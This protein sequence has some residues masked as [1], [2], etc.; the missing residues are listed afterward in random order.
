MKTDTS[1]SVEQA[2]G[3]GYLFV[4]LP[5]FLCIALPLLISFVLPEKW[6]ANSFIGFAIIPSILLGWV[7]WSWALPRWRLWAVKRVDDIELLFNKAIQAQLM[8]PAGHF[9]Q[10]T[11]I[12]STKQKDELRRIMMEKMDTSDEYVVQ[13]ITKITT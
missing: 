12:N 7:W 2:I 8:W 11:E 10:K 9:F 6:D 5:V 3:R 4:N 13:I 1:L